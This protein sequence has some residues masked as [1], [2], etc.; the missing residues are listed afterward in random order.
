LNICNKENDSG[1][2]DV[3]YNNNKKIYGAQVITSGILLVT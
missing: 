2:V 3:S 1:C